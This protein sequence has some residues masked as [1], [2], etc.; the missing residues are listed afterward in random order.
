M[1]SQPHTPIDLQHVR[2]EIEAEVRARR[3]AGEYPPGFEREMDALFARFAPPE[4]SED[5]DAALERAEETVA[6]EPVIP[7]ASRNPALAIVKRVVS[8]LIGWYHVWIVQQV[9][10]LGSTITH[11][12]RLLGRR[13]DTVE[14]LTG[15]AARVRAAGARVTPERPD[16]TWGASVVAA[17]TGATFTAV[18]GRVLVAECGRGGLLGQLTAAGV[19]AYGV[20]PRRDAADDAVER[21]LEVRLDDAVGHLDGVEKESLH[22]VVLRACVERLTTGELL[23]LADVAAARVAPGGVVVVCSLTR[24][25]W[26]T[27]ATAVEADLSPGHPLHAATWRAI[28]EERGFDDV[29][30]APAGE[31]AYVVTAR[32]A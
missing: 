4:A 30:T 18:G 32:R 31:A 23:E 10:A 24:A 11:T 6:L 29:T 28:F 27:D 12:L 8:K 2:R 5:F 21:G 25:A 9:T 19:D 22:G 20:E 1:S 3:A 15:D 7:I 17:F 14:R 16:D 26:G 13:V